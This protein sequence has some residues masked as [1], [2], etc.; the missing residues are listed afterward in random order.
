MV[1]LNAPKRRHLMKQKHLTLDDRLR[2]QHL[3]EDGCSIRY[4]ADRL[5]KSPST[6]S[7][8][9]K[10]H[11]TNFKPSYCDCLLRSS[12]GIKHV[13]GDQN[14]NRI[15]SRCRKARN[16]CTDYS[17]AYCDILLANSNGM[18]NSC[19]KKPYCHF[20]HS[21]YDG[22]KAHNKYLN[23]L[24]N[25]RNGYDC[26][27][28]ELVTIDS[29]VSPLI[30]KGQS[31]YH[32]MQTHKEEIGVSESTIRRMIHDT[33]LSC[34]NIDMRA[35]VQRKI[36]K[37][38]PSNY[39][40]SIIP[41]TEHLYEDYQTFIAE[42]P[43]TLVVEMDCVE[44]SKDSTSAILTLHFVQFHLQLGILM[45]HHNSE[46]VIAALDKI[47][48]S[49]GT[50][51]FKKCFPLI[52]TDN[53]SEFED[54]PEI[55]RSINKGK[56]TRVYFCEPNRSNEKGACE[57]NH[58]LIRYVIPKGTNLDIFNQADISLM[59]NHINSFKRSSLFG[60]S[61][62]DFAKGI[63]PDDFFILLGLEQIPP[64]EV[65]LKPSLIKHI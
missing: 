34:R 8:K 49:L 12:C 54:I 48:E 25:S 22:S 11:A 16:H 23:S 64:D 30:L 58:K 15:C 37:R 4:I 41:K 10:K 7:R 36:H 27:Y 52:L 61:P 55:E 17:K 63:I 5:D 59:M 50:K 24:T 21:T 65:L 3:I 56:R 13:C 40:K 6:I 19:R 31:I 43:D 18:C 20:E 28:E 46:C 53:G 1:L 26:T 32:I 51:L 62:Y 38:K 29:I 44:G 42:H 45:E 60:K 14:C 33:E 35:V 47:E 39:K 2:I 57:N 9:L